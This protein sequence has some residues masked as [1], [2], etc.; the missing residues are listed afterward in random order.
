MVVAQYDL[1]GQAD[2]VHYQD[3]D[4]HELEC[5]FG[6]LPRC[7]EEIHEL[8]VWDL[9]HDQSEPSQS[10]VRNKRIYLKQHANQYEQCARY[11]RDQH[12]SEGRANDVGRA[13]Y[14]LEIEQVP[15]F[16]FSLANDRYAIQACVEDHGDLDEYRV[17]RLVDWLHD[18]VEV[19]RVYSREALE[20]GREYDQL[21]E[22]EEERA[23]QKSPL[24]CAFVE[25]DQA[26]LV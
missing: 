11:H 22:A 13:H 7:C 16:P 8:N 15:Q 3:S 26:P 4:G 14:P 24:H 18:L 17:H 12:I 9:E 1:H 5:S 2:T 25:G 19:P 21:E 10:T 20:D 23:H 6:L